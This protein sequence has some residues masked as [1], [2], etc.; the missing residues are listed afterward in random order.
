MATATKI[1]LSA[2]EYA[3]LPEPADGSKQELVR[4]EVITMPSLGFL[5]G[6]VQLN[7]ATLLKTFAGQWKL[8]RVT[9]ESGVITEP[10]PNIVRG[11]DG[12][13]WSYERLPANE[14]PAAY[15]DVAAELCVEVRSLSNTDENMTR[16]ARE[17]FASGVKM[18]WVVDPEERTVT[19]YRQPGDGRVLWEDATISGEDVLPGFS[20][21]IADF[22]Q[23]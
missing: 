6:V 12:A 10:G 20:C 14:V 9:F 13:Y 16:T 15:A 23:S 1:L 18:V 3:R 17:Y 22:F 4:G 5:H 21:A 7:I 8:G 2:E 19:V 11:P